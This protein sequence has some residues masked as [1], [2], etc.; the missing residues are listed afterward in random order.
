MVLDVIVVVMVVRV[1]ESMQ[2]EDMN[3]IDVYC[4]R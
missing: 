4:M 2:G 1:I 3:I